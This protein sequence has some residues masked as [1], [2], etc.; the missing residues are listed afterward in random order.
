M[1]IERVQQ[2]STIN[3]MAHETSK[4]HRGK[5]LPNRLISS[6]RGQLCAAVAAHTQ[7]WFAA[8]GTWTFDDLLLSRG[9]QACRGRSSSTERPA[10]THVDTV[11]QHS[12]KN[13][14]RQATYIPR[15]CAVWSGSLLCEAVAVVYVTLCDISQC[16]FPK[17]AAMSCC[18][19]L[20]RGC[21]CVTPLIKQW[22]WAH[23]ARLATR[24]LQHHTKFMR[25]AK[26]HTKSCDNI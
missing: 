20:Q 3:L 22:V 17:W 19:L 18:L 5:A 6:Y 24:G 8:R 11:L 13:K 7:C 15:R 4:G 21:T 9:F 14:S 12:S 10:H 23:W 25:L 26:E 16:I 1:F 2:R